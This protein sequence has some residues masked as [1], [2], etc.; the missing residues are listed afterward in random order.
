V[1][2]EARYRSGLTR[3]VG[4]RVSAGKNKGLEG[5]EAALRRRGLTGPRRGV[6]TGGVSEAA[7]RVRKR[8][9]PRAR[10]MSEMNHKR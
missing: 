8:P 5:P 6:G 7:G 10:S 2:G 4:T 1:W 3:A 9:P